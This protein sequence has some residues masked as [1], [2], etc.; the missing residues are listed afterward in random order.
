MATRIRTI[1]I[2]LVAALSILAAGGCTHT[3]HIEAPEDAVAV[4]LTLRVQHVVNV[5]VADASH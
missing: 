1:H 3:V 5:R 2:A 4:D